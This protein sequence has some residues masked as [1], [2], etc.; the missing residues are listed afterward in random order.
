M[1]KLELEKNFD[2]N[3]F[4]EPENKFYPSYAWDWNDVLTKEGIKKQLD[5]FYDRNIRHIYVIPLTPEFRP[6]TMVTNLQPPYLSD[7]YFEMFKFAVDYAH[8]KGM[9]VGLYDEAGWPSGN[10]NFLV[11][12]ENDDYKLVAFDEDS[13]EVKVY[14]NLADSTNLDAAKRFIE[15]VHDEYK[16]HL[17]DSWDKIAPYMFTD[18]PGVKKRP[19]TKTIKA[20]YKKRYGEELDLE[21]LRAFDDPEF[22]IRFHDLCA[23]V[24]CNNYFKPLKEWCNANGILSTGHLNGEDETL[25]ANRYGYHQPMRQLRMMDMPAVDVIW[26]QIY[27]DHRSVFFPRLAS[28]AAEQVGTGLSLTESISVYGSLPYEDIRYTLGFQ[29]V[30]GVNNM[31]YTLLMY[32]NDGYY[33]IRQRPSFT[34]N[35]PA[36]EMLAN[37]NKYTARLTYMLNVGRPDIKCALYMP[38]RDIWAEDEDTNATAARYDRMGYDIEEHHGQ[39]DIADDDLLLN[40]DDEKL[41]LGVISMGAAN[42]TVLYIPQCKYMTDE[43][44]ARIEIFVSGGGEVIRE[45]NMKY[46]PAA[47][48]SGDNGTIRVHKRIAGEDELY[49]LFNESDKDANITLNLGE[50]AYLIDAVTGSVYYAEENEHFTSGEMKVFIKT[51]KPMDAQRI[52]HAERE[53]CELKDFTMK[54]NYAFTIDKICAKRVDCDDDAKVVELGDWRKYNG[55]YFSGECTY[56]TYFAKPDAEKIVLDLGQVN[57]SCQVIVNGHDLG[58]AMMPPYKFVIDP[59]ILTDNNKLEIIVQNT[60][61]NAF[62]G[63]EVPDEWESKHIGPYHE[64]TIEFE[65]TLLESGLIGPVKLYEGK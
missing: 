31:N 51:S 17:G 34:A 19:F 6:H 58:I 32:N 43:V 23:D 14:P 44:K 28:A 50:N 40:C 20:E 30:R 10:A 25:F 18:E 41:R 61:A 37:F 1:M 56:V 27:K 8:S 63:F 35:L 21:K 48:V 52:V 65:K 4:K 59:S 26:R 33:V 60:A 16:K 9:L 39:F 13:N 57:Y 11:P 62:V 29:Y 38:L 47:D 49:L 42:Y 55:E 5:E 22:N 15:L 36:G 46:Y 2:I 64:R 12:S 53:I 7:G 3:S 24:F 45:G 54:K